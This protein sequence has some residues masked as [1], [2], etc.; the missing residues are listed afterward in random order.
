MNEQEKT[1][2]LICAMAAF[3]LLFYVVIMMYVFIGVLH[4]NS[5]ENFITG[6]FFEIIGFLVLMF[7]VFGSILSKS[8]KVGYMI[9]LVMVTVFYT[10][11]LDLLNILG[12]AV[13]SF[14]I[15]TLLHLIL[16]FGYCFV[17][18]PMYI[19]GKR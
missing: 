16:L 5:F 7:V 12:I 6:M 4:I 18:I 11:L 14:S 17:S 19:M 13:M 8:V 1:K 15:F 3:L 2:S 10:V 9:P